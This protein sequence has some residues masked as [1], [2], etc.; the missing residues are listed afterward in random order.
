MRRF[1]VFGLAAIFVLVAGTALL[2]D[3]RVRAYLRGPALEGMRILAAPTR[4]EPGTFPEPGELAHKLER[5]G[6]VEVSDIPPEAGQFRVCPAGIELEQRTGVLPWAPA[7]RHVRVFFGRDGITALQAADGQRIPPPLELAGEDLATGGP[8]QA[9]LQGSGQVPRPCRDAVLAAE[10]RHFFT[11]PGID[12]VAMVRAIISNVTPGGSTQGG[13]TLTQQLVK[14][15]F[16]SPRRTLTRKA[17]E[18]VIALLLEAR[19]TKRELLGR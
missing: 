13:S 11:H 5:L 18:A 7:P 16:L 3:R 15:T 2:V 8:D 14:N 12:P 19:A 4:L 6:Y 9:R 1:V 10:D 17:Q